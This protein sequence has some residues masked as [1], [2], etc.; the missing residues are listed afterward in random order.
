MDK[1]SFWLWLQYGIGYGGKTKTILEKCSSAQYIYESDDNAL[2]KGGCTPKI[3]KRL[4][5]KNPADFKDTI[6]FCAKHSLKI[7]TPDSEFYPKRLLE[8]ENYPLALFVRGDHTCLNGDNVAVIGS[9]TPCAYGESA[10]KEIVSV[11]SK[12]NT[13]VVSGGALGIDSIAHIS[14]IENGGKTVLVMGCGHGTPYLTENSELRKQVT[15]H[16]AVVSEYPPFSPVS[17]DTFPLRN[18]II[19]G[20]CE[21][22]VIVEAAKR[23]GTFN[24]AKHTKEQGRRLFVV[25]GDITSGRFDGSNQLIS[26]GAVPVFSGA[27]ILQTIK[28][29]KFSIT[30]GKHNQA[31]SFIGLDTDASS[32]KKGRGKKTTE[33][34]VVDKKTSENRKIIPR[35]VPEGISK[36]AEIVYNIMSNG[37]VFLDEITRASGLEVRKVLVALTELEMVGAASAIGPNQ[38]ELNYE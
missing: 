16:G 37:V 29:K 27:D 5:E 26:E 1:I 23:S 12:N 15:K 30:I 11:L 20:M 31:D 19:S 33:K 34:P 2:K 35:N 7:I 17:F 28:G 9:R 36:H 21:G 32:T 3:I 13:T 10:A 18:R 8:I 24:T 25:P 6:D 22:V 38:Y 4:K 14:A